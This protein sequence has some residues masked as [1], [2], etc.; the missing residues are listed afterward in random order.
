MLLNLKSIE[1]DCSNKISLLNEKP[2]KKKLNI[3]ANINSN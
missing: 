1:R 2:E 3:I